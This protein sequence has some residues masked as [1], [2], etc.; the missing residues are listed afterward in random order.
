[1][2]FNGRFLS[3]RSAFANVTCCFFLVKSPHFLSFTFIFMTFYDAYISTLCYVSFFL[4]S[5]FLSATR[6][7]RARFYAVQS[8]ALYTLRWITTFL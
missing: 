7:A 6:G 8:C 5:Y 1:M 2:V 4:H 3:D